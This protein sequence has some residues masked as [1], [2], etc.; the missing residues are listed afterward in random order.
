LLT[1]AFFFEKEKILHAKK[2]LSLSK[3]PCYFTHVVENCLRDFLA[4]NMKFKSNQFEDVS[5]MTLKVLLNHLNHISLPLKGLLVLDGQVLESMEVPIKEFSSGE[6]QLLRREAQWS[7]SLLQKIPLLI[8]ASHR[9]DQLLISCQDLLTKKFHS[10]D[11]SLVPCILPIVPEK[12]R[13][14]QHLCERLNVLTNLNFTVHKDEMME[15]QVISLLWQCLDQ[16]LLQDEEVCQE[17]MSILKGIHCLAQRCFDSR[18]FRINLM[19]TK[20]CMV[21][22]KHHDPSGPLGA[23]DP[24]NLCSPLLFSD[25]G[26]YSWSHFGMDPPFAFEFTGCMNQTHFHASISSHFQFPTFGGGERDILEMLKS[27]ETLISLGCSCNFG[28]PLGNCSCPGCATEK[29]HVLHPGLLKLAIVAYEK[30]ILSTKPLEWIQTKQGLLHR[31]VMQ[32]FSHLSF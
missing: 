19:N 16:F 29:S 12:R 15:A 13:T 18:L 9:V 20:T 5:Y 6:Q 21:C 7:P 14:V 30:A 10:R 25:V 27:P 22:F 24:L 32:I 3:Q 4:L 23:C 8:K 28:S 11:L 31:C 1:S 17:Q 2:M 26:Q